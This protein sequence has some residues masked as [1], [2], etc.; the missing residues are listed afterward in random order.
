M[1][2]RVLN[3]VRGL[4]PGKKP[5]HLSYPQVLATS[6]RKKPVS[7]P[8]RGAAALSREQQKAADFMAL[9]QPLQRQLQVYCQ[10]MLRDRSEV[11]DV[12]QTVVMTAFSRF[13]RYAEGTNF[14]AWMFR[15]PTLEAFNRNRKRQPDP[16]GKFPLEPAGA[17]EEFSAPDD[18]A[19]L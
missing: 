2:D 11:E 4:H 1:A 16:W 18:L 15:F 5:A 10:R 7:P 13:D 9:L 6:T 19:S 8:R 17:P 3:R 14:R 12:L